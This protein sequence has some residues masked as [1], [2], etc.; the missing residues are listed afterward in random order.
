MIDEMVV[1]DGKSITRERKVSFDLEDSSSD[2]QSSSSPK[3]SRFGKLINRESIS[4]DDELNLCLL[5]PGLRGWDFRLKSEVYLYVRNISPIEFNKDAFSHLV[6]PENHKQMALAFVKAHTRE[7]KSDDVLISDT[8]KGKGGG[9]VM[10]LHGNPERQLNRILE[11]AAKWN[12]VVLIDEA[13]IFL[14]ARNDDIQ[15]SALVSVFLRVLEYHTGVLI[16]TTNRVETFDN[17]LRSRITI[18]LKYPD[19][20]QRSRKILWMKFLVMAKVITDENSA[21]WEEEA[22]RLSSRSMNG[23]DIKN[24]VRSAQTLALEE[25]AAFS[26]SHIEKVL[27]IADDF[28]FQV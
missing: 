11:V 18:A 7:D 23:R 17:A 13:D 1:D 16:L 9:M 2:D 6:L 14:Q 28:S 12:S 15:R 10:L 21:K 27:S 20:D 4:D 8:I 24:A 3:S 26:I 25:K 22:E 5:P 19:L